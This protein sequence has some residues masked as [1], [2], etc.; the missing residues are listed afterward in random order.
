MLSPY[1]PSD[2][3]QN[4]LAYLPVK[5]IFSL[6]R[7]NRSWYSIYEHA[8]K[9]HISLFNVQAFVRIGPQKTPVEAKYSFALDCV[10]FG[11][12][13]RIFTFIPT[14]TAKPIYCNPTR[15]RQVKVEFGEWCGVDTKRH[16]GNTGPLE[17]PLDNNDDEFSVGPFDR[18]SDP[19]AHELTRYANSKVHDQYIEAVRKCYYLEETPDKDG[20]IV[21]YLGD[22]DMII[23]CKIKD[24]VVPEEEIID[25]EDEEEEDSDL[26]KFS[27]FEVEFIKVRTSWLVGGTTRKILPP[28][29]HKQIYSSRYDLLNEITLSNN[30]HRYN[31]YCP[32]VL[33]WILSESNKNDKETIQ[34]CQHLRN[35]NGDFTIRDKF[36]SALE[37]KSIEKQKMWKYSFVSRFFS[38]PE[39][40]SDTFEQILDRFSRSEESQENT[41]VPNTR[42]SK[43]LPWPL[44]IPGFS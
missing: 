43:K 20:E 11:L 31:H 16:N 4:I 34:L 8:I 37:E 28:E 6:R 23:K 36:E 35:T 29:F 14:V 17:N 42:N 41:R 26:N 22:K 19:P 5:D 38:D 18:P 12:D 24:S 3:V 10:G 33:K 30:I 1:L 2:V 15:L 13:S 9:Q 40:S 7:V 39:N 21:T 27:S 25:A 44:K 32:K